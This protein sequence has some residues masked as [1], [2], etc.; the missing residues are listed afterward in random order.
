[1]AISFFYHLILCI[2]VSALCRSLHLCT[3]GVDQFIKVMWT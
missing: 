2:L 3:S 1:M